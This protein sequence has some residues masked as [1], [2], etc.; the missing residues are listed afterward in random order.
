VLQQI[1][2]LPADVAEDSSDRHSDEQ[3]E[4][5]RSQQADADPELHR[6]ALP[7]LDESEPVDAG[8]EAP[9]AAVIPLDKD[10]HLVDVEDRAADADAGTRL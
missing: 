3:G 1:R 5:D 6:H 2:H 4:R 8:P 9:R 10:L 7:G